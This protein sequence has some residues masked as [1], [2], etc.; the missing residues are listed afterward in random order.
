[1]KFTAYN[2]AISNQ[3]AKDYDLDRN[4]NIR[5]KISLLR[6]TRLVTLLN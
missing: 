5:W 6:T 4:P 2:N 1:M 3:I